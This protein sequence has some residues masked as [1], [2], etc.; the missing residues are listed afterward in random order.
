MTCELCG[1]EL[2]IGSWP[3]CKD[4]HAPGH[5]NVVGDEIPG[6]FVQEHF[7]HTPEVFYSKHKMAQRADDLGLQPFVQ[8]KSGKES[9]KSSKVQRWI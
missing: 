1:G 4:G 2:V 6:G 7:G 9:D 3:F 8:W 5:A